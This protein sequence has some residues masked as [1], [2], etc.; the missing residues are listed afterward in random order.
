[1]DLNN[2]EYFT[3][4]NGII[5]LTI[6]IGLVFL[7]AYILSIRSY[8]NHINTDL[9]TP[10]LFIIIGCTVIIIFVLYSKLY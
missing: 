10:K 9:I 7:S 1:M 6:I 8:L 4:S 5:T 3:W 2:K